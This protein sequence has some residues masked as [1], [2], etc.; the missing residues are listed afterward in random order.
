MSIFMTTTITLDDLDKKRQD[1]SFEGLD[2]SYGE[3]ISLVRNKELVISPEYQRMFRW[4]SV[5]QSLFIESIL[6]RIPIPQIF[7]IERTDGV[8]ELTDGLQ[9]ISTILHFFGPEELGE[10][11]YR[12]VF[13]DFEEFIDSNN[14]E[15]SCSTLRLEGCKLIK[16]LNN[17]TIKE[18]TVRDRLIIK[19]SSIR[20]VVVK[21]QSDE[22]FRYELFNR[23]NTGGSPLSPQ[24]I[25]NCSA[26]MI[27][28]KGIKFY[29]FLIEC[30]KNPD[31]IECIATLSDN[32]REQKGA[33][34]LVL[35]FFALKNAQELFKKSIR[36]WLDE[37]MDQVL[38]QNSDFD[39][40]EQKSSFEQVFRCIKRIMGENAFVK[41]RSNNPFGGL[42][43]AYFEAVS[44]AFLNNIG[45]I[46]DN[47]KT[48]ERIKQTVINVFES[49]EFK[50]NTGTGSN[51]QT[52][53]N[54]RISMIDRAI[55]NVLNV[56]NE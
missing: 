15:Q 51:T 18:M 4:T 44:K 46:N 10:E 52:K 32:V 29:D 12:K 5:Q 7:I 31:F 35:R 22:Y 9:R 23:L 27:G 55:Q 50:E 42:A 39:Y 47:R 37:Y 36:E 11:V 38:F 13:N 26:R 19:R 2:M 30:T 45:N 6:L 48:D 17:Q 16:E 34:E 43:P 14:Q 49:P 54:N 28:E 25:R 20:V 8:W 41:Y 53:L 3:I 56:N 40:H 33:E 21:R 24:E 1:L